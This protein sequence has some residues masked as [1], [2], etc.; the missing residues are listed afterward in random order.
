MKKIGITFLAVILLLSLFAACGGNEPATYTITFHS[1]GGSVIDPIT[2]TPGENVV[3][4]VPEKEG[5][6]FQG[7]Y[8]N[9]NLT[10]NP[11]NN[12]LNN[13]S[14]GNK[15]FWAK[16]GDEPDYTITYK[17][18]NNIMNAQLG[19]N[20]KYK[21]SDNQD[22]LLP[23]PG[24]NGYTF[25]G[26]YD[27]QALTGERIT[28]IP[29][30]SKGNKIFYAKWEAIPY[31][32]TF[33]TNFEGYTIDPVT[34]TIAEMKLLPQ[35]DA[36]AYYT[37][38]GW[39]A[40]PE[41]SGYSYTNVSKGSTGDKV[42]Y[43]KWIAEQFA[44]TYELN[45]GTFT[46]NDGHPEYY[47]V[48]GITLVSPLKEGFA[49]GGWYDNAAL[50]GIAIETITAGETGPKTFY[51]KWLTIEN[52]ITYTLNNG[53]FIGSYPQ[54]YTTAEGVTLVNP[55]RQGYTFEGWFD[56]A[57]FSGTPIT[58]I[59]AGSQG[60]KHFYAKW[61]VA[62][63]I[64][65]FELN[66][67]S[68]TDPEG[69]DFTVTMFSSPVDLNDN[70]YRPTRTGYDFGGWFSNSAFTGS[71]V[72]T[73]PSGITANK[74]YYAKW[75]IRTYKVYFKVGY[76]ID[77]II[78]NY[79]I[80]T[81]VPLPNAPSRTGYNFDGWY[82]DSQLTSLNTI[83]IPVG[84]TGEKIIYAKWVPAEYTITYNPNGGEMPGT[85]ATSYR[86]NEITPLP[87]PVKSG[88]IFG[89]WYETNRTTPDVASVFGGVLPEGTNGNKT[90][91]A[92]WLNGM[93]PTE[94]VQKMEAE[95][96]DL[97]GKSGPGGSGSAS[98]GEMV[99]LEYTNASNGQCIPWTR[100]PGVS[101]DWEFK[102]D[103]DVTGASVVI[104]FGSEIGNVTFDNSSTAIYINGVLYT[105]PWSVA[106]NDR[107][108]NTFTISG[109]NLRAGYNVITI[110]VLEN[111]LAVGFDAGGPVFD[112]ITVKAKA[113]IAWSPIIWKE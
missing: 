105:Q 30:G 43:A 29:A 107:T 104:C 53:Q 62:Q 42:F 14:K 99:S 25:A 100:G 8:N 79:N 77:D 111:D 106:V 72:T 22:T 49:F 10:G 21:E 87:V 54:G 15:E 78:I 31:T 88:F 32:I 12:I 75:N 9:A 93:L 71:A 39:Y 19:W 7:W 81:A 109:I 56:N 11:F 84:S 91:Y 102:V 48:E 73:L 110:E 37:F 38:G 46:D 6:V 69:G 44:I 34:Y 41:F 33:V 45:G 67:G 17:D 68:F 95:H 5:K 18:G 23:I 35:P 51:A 20:T 28:S 36:R 85:Y 3:L 58:V 74:T 61:S 94:Q 92:L 89:G 40:D 83:G 50:E 55:I 2:F 59:E 60:N 66:N 90:F 112:Y 57:E 65:H 97:T 26:W 47:T 76:G 13:A 98:E 96:T 64:I 101:I 1:E 82:N 80:E 113:N 4:P 27:N 103:R 108:F 63:Y 70:K 16:W 24:K 86:Y 52:S